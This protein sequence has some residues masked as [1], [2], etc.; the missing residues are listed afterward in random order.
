MD[1]KR[2]RLSCFEDDLEN[3]VIVEILFLKLKVFYGNSELRN[4]V[5][6]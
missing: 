1:I 5:E 4:I 2:L 3:I 6:E